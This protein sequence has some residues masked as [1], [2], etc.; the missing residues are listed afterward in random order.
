MTAT[1][2]LHQKLEA[3]PP[4]DREAVAAYLLAEWEAREGRHAGWQRPERQPPALEPVP[5]SRIAHLAGVLEGGP[6]DLSTNKRYLEGL[7]RPSET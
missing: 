1:E 7:G 6:P 5:Y 4:R 2:Q 3:L